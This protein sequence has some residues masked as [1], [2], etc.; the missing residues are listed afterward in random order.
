MKDYVH[1]VGRTARAG[2]AGKALLFLHPSEESYISVL[3]EEQINIKQAH[4]ERC[5]KKLCE[6]RV[7]CVYLD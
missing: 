3:R 1:R 4:H 2:T 7:G 6:V 5:M